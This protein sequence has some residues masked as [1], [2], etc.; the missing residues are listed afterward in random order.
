VTAIDYRK[1][2]YSGG[3]NSDCVEAAAITREQIEQ[4]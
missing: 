1:S 2:S 3:A 4:A